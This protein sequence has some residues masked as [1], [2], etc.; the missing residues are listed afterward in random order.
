MHRAFF[1]LTCCAAVYHGHTALDLHLS[2]DEAKLGAKHLIVCK[3]MQ[4]ATP[5]LM[6]RMLDIAPMS[7]GKDPPCNPSTRG[8]NTGFKCVNKEWLCEVQLHEPWK[9]RYQKAYHKS[10]HILINRVATNESQ[11]DYTVHPTPDFSST[12]KGERSYVHP[13]EEDILVESDFQRKRRTI[14]ESG[15]SDSGRSDSGESDSGESNSG[16]SSLLGVYDA[17]AVHLTS[18][19]AIV[20]LDTAGEVM[21]KTAR[22]PIPNHEGVI[23]NAGRVAE[24]PAVQE[25]NPRDSATP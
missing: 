8:R 2:P 20:S 21:R 1:F 18:G 3:C 12:D 13:C 7:T 5:K 15:Q 4:D 19:G 23:P 11:S 6:F 10:V 16:K 9:E 14:S 17:A 22:L 25:A 24:T